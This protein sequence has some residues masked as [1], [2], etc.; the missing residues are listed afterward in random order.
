LAIASIGRTIVVGSLAVG[1]FVA[2]PPVTLAVFVSVAGALAA[3]LTVSA[4]GLPAPPAAIVAGVVHVTVAPA[5]E[6]VQPVPL[7]AL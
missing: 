7:A 4:I 1:A 3:T 2:P 6:H 5:A